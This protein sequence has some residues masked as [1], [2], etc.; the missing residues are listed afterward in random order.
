MKRLIWAAVTFLLLAT[1][2]RA[3][4][5]PQADVAAGYLIFTSSRVLPF[6]WRAAA[7]L[8]LS[9]PVIGWE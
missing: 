7:G 9:T 3:Q 6:Q 1:V 8:L 4:E 2:S 5:T